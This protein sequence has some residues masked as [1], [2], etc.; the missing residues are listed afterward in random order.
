MDFKFFG[1]CNMLQDTPHTIFSPNGN[2][3]LNE[4]GQKDNAAERYVNPLY[5]SAKNERNEWSL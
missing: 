3:L 2:P 1:L 4:N 5:I